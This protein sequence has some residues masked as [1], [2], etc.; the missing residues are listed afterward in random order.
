MNHKEYMA[1]YFHEGL[2]EQYH[3]MGGLDV[4]AIDRGIA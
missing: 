3:E 2:D 4:Y 1:N